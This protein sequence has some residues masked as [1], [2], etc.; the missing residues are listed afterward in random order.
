MKIYPEEEM[1]I[2]WYCKFLPCSQFGHLYLPNL[3][4]HRVNGR[5][6]GIYQAEVRHLP[7]A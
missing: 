5:I 2:P 7:H 4:Q 6:L 1:E 3:H